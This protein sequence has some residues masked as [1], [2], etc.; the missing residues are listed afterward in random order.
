[1]A[2]GMICV[3]LALFG[4]PAGLIG[5]LR[6]GERSVGSPATTAVV[7]ALLAA[8]ALLAVATSRFPFLVRRVLDQVEITASDPVSYLETDGWM[9]DTNISALLAFRA[10]RRLAP[11]FGGTNL[12][13]QAQLVPAFVPGVPIL[14]S[15]LLLGAIVLV[16]AANALLD[17]GGA[18]AG[19]PIA[20]SRRPAW[21][22][23]DTAQRIEV[24]LTLLALAVAV[25]LIGAWVVTL[26]RSGRGQ[27]TA[28][29]VLLL[30]AAGAMIMLVS[31]RRQNGFLGPVL[32][33]SGVLTISLYL[34]GLVLLP[35]LAWRKWLLAGLVSAAI[36][37]AP[38]V[39]D[40]ALDG[41]PTAGSLV[42]WIALLAAI[43]W[44]YTPGG[45]HTVLVAADRSARL[46]RIVLAMAIA[47]WMIGVVLVFGFSRVLLA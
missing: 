39:A 32:T 44:R 28:R 9:K 12:A 38:L 6:S 19:R 31:L 24:L 42:A 36:V 35:V 7:V 40:G 26:V 43:I 17:A 34:G 8:F 47:K 46:A 33:G 37:F 16:G 41:P 27:G 14:R 30:F 20:D 5:E 25:G 45:A 3:E 1:M 2:L 10:S 13:P 22:T 29:H 21:L 23:P 18:V 11:E 15:V 4:A